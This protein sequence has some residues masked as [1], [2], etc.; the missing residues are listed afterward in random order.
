MLHLP[1]EILEQIAYSVDCISDYES[2][3]ITNQFFYHL[4]STPASYK[5]L[6][7]S[8][9]DQDYAF[10]IFYLL[11]LIKTKKARMILN[12]IIK[13]PDSFKLQNIGIQVLIQLSRY[14]P[15]TLIVN[16]E[17]WKLKLI[18]HFLSVNAQNLDSFKPT[19]IS[20]LNASIQMSDE[21]TIMLLLNYLTVFD[22]DTNWYVP[23]VTK[24]NQKLF[25]KLIENGASLIGD[26]TMIIQ[27]IMN[28]ELIECLDSALKYYK[29]TSTDL[30]Q[31]AIRTAWAT[32]AFEGNIQIA[33]MLIDH[34]NVSTRM[35]DNIA[36]L[37]ACRRNYSELLKLLFENGLT[38]MDLND[39]LPLYLALSRNHIEAVQ[40]LIEN[41]VNIHDQDEAALREAARTGSFSMTQ[42]LVEA[43][44]DISALNYDA[45]RIAKQH[46]HMDVYH[47]L[48]NQAEIQHGIN[49]PKT[50]HR[51]FINQIGELQWIPG[52]STRTWL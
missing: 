41:G 52:S 49:I 5:R 22:L 15:H 13:T 6:L 31:S 24:Q 23:L 39:G 48:L 16:N 36:L 50:I 35:S 25:C 2:L 33:R 17:N 27:M 18:S 14:S 28:E 1:V 47:Y 45:I 4:L 11:R 10:S 20:I 46:G 32:V 7:Y 44:A 26:E 38:S 29:N 8:M 3:V 19:L 21:P 34:H 42:L 40:V 51:Q 30:Y 37:W 12:E 43:G 9:F